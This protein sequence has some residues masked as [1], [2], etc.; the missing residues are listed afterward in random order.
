MLQPDGTI[1]EG[2]FEMNIFKGPAGKEEV[3][4]E[5]INEEIKESQYTDEN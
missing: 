4:Q 1:L 5:D 3:I 2:W